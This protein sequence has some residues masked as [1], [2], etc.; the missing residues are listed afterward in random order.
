MHITRSCA[1]C[2]A[3][4][5]HACFTPQTVRGRCVLRA[6]RVT[7]SQLVDGT[8]AVPRRTCSL[9]LAI[10]CEH[11]CALHHAM[12]RRRGHRNAVPVEGRQRSVR[13]GH[14]IGNDLFFR[15]CVSPRLESHDLADG[16]TRYFEMCN[17]VSGRSAAD[18]L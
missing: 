10:E 1:R 12:L 8:I 11:A 16:S 7:S 9:M 4:A 15:L 5:E 13:L 6:R 17:P 3:R 18:V 2:L 14:V